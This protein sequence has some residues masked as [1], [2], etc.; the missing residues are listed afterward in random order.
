MLRR[1][2]LVLSTLSVA[3]SVQSRPTNDEQDDHL[4]ARSAEPF[5]PIL[6]PVT[7]PETLLG[8]HYQVVKR[9]P[10]PLIFMAP[11]LASSLA[12]P[13]GEKPYVPPV[14]A[15]TK[16]A[17]PFPRY[18]ARREHEANYVSNVKPG[19]L[20]P[21]YV[22]FDPEP[23]PDSTSTSAAPSATSG[24]DSRTADDKKGGKEDKK[25][26]EKAEDKGKEKDEAKASTK[27]KDGKKH[28]SG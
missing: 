16:R 8:R 28:K 25:E 10:S 9:D 20:Y 11:A 6:I 5:S 7:E 24:V 18:L 21:S 22:P 4:R 15:A 13:K 3:L 26:K 2:L 14:P 12:Q 23:S 1:V 19:P 27:S 17:M